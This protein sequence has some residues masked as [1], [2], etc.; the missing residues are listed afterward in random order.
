MPTQSPRP[1]RSGYWPRR[2][3]RT[4]HGPG[5]GRD[6]ASQADAVRARASL[7]GQFAS[8]G[9]DPTGAEN[10]VM[11]ARLLGHPRWRAKTR[12]GELLEAFGLAEA[13]RPVRTYSGG[14]RRRL[15]IAAGL[16]VTPNSSSSTPPA[17]SG[18]SPLR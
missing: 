15:A 18:P 6:V 13:A 14:M 8:V 10:L 7:T 9:E 2:S 12:A 17:R 16:V 1:P 3:G 4:P 11:I 5:A